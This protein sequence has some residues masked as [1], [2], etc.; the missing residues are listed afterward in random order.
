MFDLFRS[1]Q[2][3]VRIML[4]VLLAMFAL[5]MLVYL[6]PG[7]GAPMGNKNDQIVAD[8]GKDAVTVHDVEVQIHNV[9]QGRQVPPDVAPVLIPQI[10][11]QAIIDRAVSY[12]AK[13]LG[14]Q[15]SERDLANMI[16]SLGPQVNQ[17]MQYRMWIE[18]MGQSVPEFEANLLLKGYQ[19]SIQNITQQGTVV[20]PE[21]VKL[22][23]RAQNDRVK[24]EYILFEP[25]KLGA[26]L[27]P[28]PQDLNN[29]F[30]QKKGIFNLPE[31]RTV[32]LIIADPAKVAETIQI[33]DTEVQ[34][35]YNSHKDQFRTPER[36]KARH[37][38]VSTAEKPKDQ[39]PKLK[40]KAEDLL[41]QIKGGAD[42]AKLPEKNSDDTGSRPKG[43]ALG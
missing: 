26:Q 24:L 11:D 31:M 2:K 17:P 1:R 32:Q 29:Y 36:I 10:V 25:S 40:S 9:L 4:G 23:Y 39:I 28:T 35:Y 34:N 41:K 6:I 16:R 22:A 21:E 15:V 12:E 14:F 37:I 43:A 20:P 38:L 42:F 8:V 13:R 7:A 18:Q 30:M 5:S 19:D 27:K 3:A 33:S